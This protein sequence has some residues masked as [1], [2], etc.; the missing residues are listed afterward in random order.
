VGATVT[1]SRA[2]H[3]VAVQREAG[4]GERQVQLAIGVEREIIS[5]SLFVRAQYSF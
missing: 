2:R 4:L 1:G 3:A 5:H